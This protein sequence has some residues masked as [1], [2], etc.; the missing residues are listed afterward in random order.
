MA[1]ILAD[2]V[3]VRTRTVGT[4]TLTLENT[5]DG[6]QSFAAIGNGNETY[7]GIT[8][9]QGNW[10]I[11][12]GTYT[13]DSSIEYLSRDSVVD[14]SNNGNLINLTEGS[15]NVYC[16]IPASIIQSLLP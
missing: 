16:T 13:T 9:Y 14:S 8:D 4:G 5:V 3:K 12:R 6:F 10:E 15:K 1:L 2:R 11:G 7:Y